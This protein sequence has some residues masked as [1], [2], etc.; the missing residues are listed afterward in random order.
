MP[1]ELA[2][3]V[4]RPDRPDV[5]PLIAASHA[6]SASLYP[7]ESNHG[8]GI[9]SLLAPEV[10]FLVLRE[11]NVA[12]GCGA[13]VTLPDGDGEL[14]AMWVEP[15]ARSRGFGRAILDRLIE[16]AGARRMRRLWLET[17][18]RQPE[19][20]GLY[21]AAAFEE[22]SSFGIYR[23]DP[24]SVFMVRHLGGQGPQVS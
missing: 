5:A 1:G 22:T 20:I 17:G 15:G 2:I 16:L 21:R 8:L 12:L 11:R 18:V 24:L 3:T 4:E 13:L 7:P 10:T 19:A 9:A 23:P 14:K 6:Y